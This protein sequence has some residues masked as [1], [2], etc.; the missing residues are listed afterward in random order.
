V[1]FSWYSGFFPNNKTD[2]NDIAEI[3]LKGNININQCNELMQT[4][5]ILA[6]EGGHIEVDAD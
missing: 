6:V 5:L 3:F 4:P 2:R 1:V